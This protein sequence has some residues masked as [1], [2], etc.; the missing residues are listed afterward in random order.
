VGSKAVAELVPGHSAE[1]SEMAGKRQGPFAL[2]VA[3]EEMI[4]CMYVLSLND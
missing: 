4:E 1:A 3:D 2:V